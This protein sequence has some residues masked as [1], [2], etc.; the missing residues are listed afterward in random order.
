LV[1]LEELTN[2]SQPSEALVGEKRREGIGSGQK[3]KWKLKNRQT[4]ETEGIRGTGENG[5]KKTDKPDALASRNEK[6]MGTTPQGVRAKQKRQ[7]PHMAVA[8]KKKNVNCPGLKRGKA[9][10]NLRGRVKS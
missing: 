8:G 7:S 1:R 5:K 3:D 9:E 10:R 4:L 2:Q 6:R